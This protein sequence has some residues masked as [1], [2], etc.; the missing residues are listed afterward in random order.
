VPGSVSRLR[1]VAAV[2]LGAVA[3]AFLYIAGSWLQVR[4]MGSRTPEGSADA[5]VVMG[6]AQYDGRPSDMLQRRL[7]TALEMWNDGRATWVAVTGGKMEGDRFTE[8]A[9]SAA[10]LVDRG[11]P[12]DR[13][14]REETGASTWESLSALAPVLRDNGV[15]STFVVTTDWHVARSVLTLREL[16][17]GASPAS[18]GP[19]QGSTARW[20]REALA[21]G[22]GRIIGFGRLYSLTG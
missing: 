12:A 1:T 4:E 10:W 2:L 21:V 3:L 17:F 7:E 6:A 18:A 22:A 5:I 20:W 9:A 8:A 13:I 16:G 19:A 15:K 11:V 14:L